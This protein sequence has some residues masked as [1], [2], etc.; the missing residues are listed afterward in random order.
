[1]IAHQSDIDQ[2]KNFYAA[3]LVRPLGDMEQ[4]VLAAVAWK[5][6]KCFCPP[7]VTDL[8]TKLGSIQLT[9]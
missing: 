3:S 2:F 6:R 1:M 9:D 5:L 4:R 8:L 7:D